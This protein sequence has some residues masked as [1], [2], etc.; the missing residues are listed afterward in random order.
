M[1]AEEAGGLFER[2]QH[3]STLDEALA[4]TLDGRGGILVLLSGEA[5]AGKTALLRR[6]LAGA[7]G[8]SASSR[9]SHTPAGSV[10]W[11]SCDPL[12]TPRPLGPFI[13]IAQET[14][15][16]LRAL[17]RTGA[18][19]HQIAAAI[20]RAAQASKP[21]IIVLEDLHWADEATLDVLSLLGR[22][23]ESIPALV[24]ATYRDDELD[25]THP[26]RQ[27]LGEL[28][29]TT[30]I[31]R[32][33]VPPLSRAAVA[34]LAAPHGLDPD[35][36]YRTTSGNPFFVTEVIAAPGADIPSTVRDAVLAR[37]A[38]LSSTATAVVE[39]V[40]VGLPHTELW[41]L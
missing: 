38:R 10:L 22:R 37:A 29:N 30:S 21:T 1:G 11:G 40:S 5:G 2:S 20:G 6:F 28:R 12:F 39:A 33:T 32:L 34:S 25:R 19:P 16:E 35:A 4:A 24:V 27:L 18:R 9:A 26:L 23:I 31:R 15:G 41:L 36:L 7:D 13:D 17:V 3:L 14:A 8:R